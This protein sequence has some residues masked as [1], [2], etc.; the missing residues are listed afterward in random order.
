MKVHEA[1]S[2][3]RLEEIVEEQLGPE[4]LKVEVR[5]DEGWIKFG[6]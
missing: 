1:L 3:K 5:G 2:G 6:K 4:N